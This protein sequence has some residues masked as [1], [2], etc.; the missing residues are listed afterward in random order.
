MG[1]GR[2]LT[3]N[4][5][6][7]SGHLPGF[8]PLLKHGFGQKIFIGYPIKKSGNPHKHWIFEKAALFGYPRLP[9]FPLFF[10]NYYDKKFK[11]I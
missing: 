2:A 1:F 4:F 5:G 6:Q 8:C 7:I 3:G 11:Y 9:T 10:L